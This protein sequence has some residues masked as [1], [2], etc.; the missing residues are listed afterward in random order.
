MIDLSACTLYKRC[1]SRSLEN[2]QT[3]M[4]QFMGN[5]FIVEILK[6]HNKKKHW[7]NCNMLTHTDILS[8][9]VYVSCYKQ[10]FVERQTIKAWKIKLKS[11][12][13]LLIEI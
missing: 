9:R 1:T 6:Q 11:I 12:S 10:Q 8:N 3:I 2:T 7:I 13:R 5:N 4:A